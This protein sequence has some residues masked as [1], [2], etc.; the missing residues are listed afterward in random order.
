MKI[1]E[2]QNRHAITLLVSCHTYNHCSTI[3]VRFVPKNLCLNY[4]M[5]SESIEEN[6]KLFQIKTE[7]I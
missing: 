7:I 5:R 2:F 3:M 6:T 1:T 4:H